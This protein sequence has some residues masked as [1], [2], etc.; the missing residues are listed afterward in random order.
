MLEGDRLAALGLLDFQ[1]TF[2]SGFGVHRDTIRTFVAAGGDLTPPRIEGET[3]M[4]IRRQVAEGVSLLLPESAILEPSPLSETTVVVYSTRDTTEVGR[5]RLDR[6]ADGYRGVW[7]DPPAGTYLIRILI[8]DAAGNAAF[9]P[10]QL[11]EVEARSV[12]VETPI[13][14]DLMAELYVRSEVNAVVHSPDGQVTA[15]AEGVSIRLYENA[16]LGEVGV[17]YGI[18][19]RRI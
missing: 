18:L 5:V 14:E 11:F 6:Q 9:T 7:A 2:D 4:L 13:S 19:D 15:V 3:G 1:V 16:G 8:A 17:L 10:L 12:V